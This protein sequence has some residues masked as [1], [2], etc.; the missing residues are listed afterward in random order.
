M[1]KVFADDV[2]LLNLMPGPYHDIGIALRT[3]GLK[4]DPGVAIAPRIVVANRGTYDETGVPV[5]VTIDSAGTRIY[6]QTVNLPSLD[7]AETDSIDFPG[8]TPGPGGN[9]YQV[10][11]W[12]SYFS[13]TNRMN[14]TVHRTV[15]VRG[16]GMASVGMSIG[17]R[18]RAGAAVTPRLVIRSADY[19]EYNVKCKCWIDSAGTRV[20]DDSAFV[21]SVPAGMTG[22]AQFPAWNVGPVGAVYDVTMFNMFPDPNPADDTLHRTTQATDQMR[23]LVAYADLGGTP[24]LLTT[25]LTAL[26]DSVELFDAANRTPTLSELQPYDGII[27]F[28]NNTFASATAFGDV[29]ADFV[30]LERPVVISTFALTSGWDVQG[31]IITGDYHAMTAGTNTQ[32]A[33]TLGWNISGHP[34]MV[35]VDTVTD[36]YR[37]QTLFAPGADSIAKWS[38]DKPYIATSANMRVIAINMYPGY[39]SPSRLTGNDWVLAYHQALL[40]GAGSGSGLE[41]KQPLAAGADFVLCQSQPNPFAERTVIRYNLPHAADVRI[42]VYDVSGRSVATLVNGAQKAGGQS[43]SWNRTDARGGRVPAGVYVCRLTSGNYTIARKLVVR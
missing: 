39:Y 19:T 10:T 35:G 41:G 8:W 23:V 1:A 18:V 15:T 22:T 26:G 4:V 29:L 27:T 36:I 30:D 13:D 33:G 28:S 43:V 6:D 42:A 5:R 3:P 14:D 21:D 17:G 16:H 24:D 37:S 32:A 40:W 25:G 11:A 7:S 12:H 2:T 9:V 34:I 20:Y 38:D 31:R